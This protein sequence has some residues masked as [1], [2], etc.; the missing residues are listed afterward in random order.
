L[1]RRMAAFCYRR[2]WFVLVVWLVL[3]VGVSVLAK[4]SGGDLLK[5]FNLPGSESQ[6]GFDVLKHQFARPGDTG[7]LVFKARNGDVQSPAVQQDVQRVLRQLQ[8]VK[9]N[10]IQS[11]TT[12]YDVGGQRFVSPKDPSIAYAELQFDVQANDVPVD[13]AT[14][15]RDVVKHANSGAVQY[16]LGGSMFTDQTQPASEF[17]GILAAVVILLIAF[18]SLLAMGLPIMTALFGIGI[19]LGI[20]Q[21]LAKVIDIPSFAQQVTA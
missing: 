10:H 9:N 1:L 14:H 12:P 7:E 2:R 3:L 17:I 8:A 11:V 13:T 20:E 5:S 21:L 19:G 6:A 18:G 4:S 16:E 15:M